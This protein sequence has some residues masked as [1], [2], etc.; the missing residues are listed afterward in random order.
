MM[1]HLRGAVTS[2]LLGG[3]CSCRVLGV[4]AYFR[5]CHSDSQLTQYTLNKL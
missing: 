2:E 4:C 1:C 5:P 3:A